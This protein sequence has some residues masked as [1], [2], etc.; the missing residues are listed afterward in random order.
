MKTLN[1]PLV[2]I[3][4][5]TYNCE[6]LIEATIRSVCSQV[7]PN[8]EYIIVDGGSKDKTLEIIDKYRQ[9]ISH[10][11][12]EKDSGIYDAMNKG[13]QLTSPNSQYVNFLNAGDVYFNKNVI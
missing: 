5:V 13:L 8:L 9:A 12:S 11:I 1:P 4:T 6:S 10:L 3:I 7:Y 2:S